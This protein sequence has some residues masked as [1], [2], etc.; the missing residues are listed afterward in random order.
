MLTPEAVVEAAARVLARD[1]YDSL[2]MRAIADEL[3]VQA[4]ALYWYFGDKRALELALFEHLMEGF[5]GRISGGDWRD[6][7]RQ[8]AQQLRAFLG[9]VRDITRLSPQGMWVGP[10]LLSQLE[11]VLGILKGAGLS[12]N[13]AAYAVNMLS[14]FVFQWAGAEADF[15]AERAEFLASAARAP[16]DPARYPNVSAARE[17]LLRWDPDGAFAFRLDAMIAGLE[18]RIRSD[19]GGSEQS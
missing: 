8:G 1:G 2:T 12:P 5:T 13:D 18:A 7:L 6:Q 4:P 3:G 9:G 16:P 17:F 19:I 15:T 10:N 14:S 11:A